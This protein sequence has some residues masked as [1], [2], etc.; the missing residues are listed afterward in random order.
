V[1]KPGA[2]RPRSAS[3]LIQRSQSSPPITFTVASIS[4][5][6]AGSMATSWTWFL[7]VSTVFPRKDWPIGLRTDL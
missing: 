3:A 7:S 5:W 2:S 6:L 4:S 1:R